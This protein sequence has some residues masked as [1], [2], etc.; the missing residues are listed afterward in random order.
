MSQSATPPRSTFRRNANTTALLD[1]A[2]WFLMA[3]LLSAMLIVAGITRDITAISF[4]GAFAFALFIVIVANK[5]NGAV[6]HAPALDTASNEDLLEL[7]GEAAVANARLMGTLY[8]WGAVA[9]LAVYT[10]TPVSWQHG[11]QYGAGMAL[12]GAICFAS[13]TA[14]TRST[15]ALRLRILKATETLAVLQGL[16]AAT[17]LAFLIMS[18]KLASTKGDW[19]ANIIFLIGGSALVLMCAVA[20]YTNRRVLPARLT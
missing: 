7:A 9:L 14:I 17:G 3:I 6:R 16:A 13:A 8:G 10:L 11:W 12:I 1:Y 20:V 19:P 4:A 5:L 2:P 15:Q 18:G